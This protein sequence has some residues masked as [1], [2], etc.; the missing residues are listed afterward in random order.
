[1]PMT[2]GASTPMHPRPW[3]TIQIERERVKDRD[4][5]AMARVYEAKVQEAVHSLY[6]ELNIRYS[7]LNVSLDAQYR[8]DSEILR[9]L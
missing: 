9:M 1:M 2:E 7:S 8:P 4:M 6:V 3:K 5:E